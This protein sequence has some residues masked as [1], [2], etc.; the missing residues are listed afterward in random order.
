MSYTGKFP[1]N[2]QTNI[3]KTEL[4]LVICS[5]CSLVQLNCFGN[6]LKC[7]MNG[8]SLNRQDTP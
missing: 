2:K 3:K 4:G 7:I 6:L 1:K 8:F 5:K